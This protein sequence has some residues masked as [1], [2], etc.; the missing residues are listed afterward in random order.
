M[1]GLKPVGPFRKASY[2]NADDACVE[3]APIGSHVVARDSKID[4]GP[5]VVASGSA[6]SAFLGTWK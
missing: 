5:V 2:S 4:Q 3:V 6:W 1:S